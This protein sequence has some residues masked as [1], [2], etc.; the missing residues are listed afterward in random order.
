MKWY[1]SPSSQ[2]NNRYAGGIATE[3]SAMNLVA[4]ILCAELDAHGITYMRNKPGNGANGHAAESNEYGAD[5]HLAIHTNARGA[6]QMSKARGC[7]VYCYAPDQPERLGTRLAQAVYNQ[8][9]PLT[10]TGDR[11]IKSGA[12]TMSEI[13]RTHAAAALVE[14][15][16]HDDVDGAVWI[17]DNVANIAYALLRAILSIEGIPYT[18]DATKPGT[19]ENRRCY[20][21]LVE[22][23]AIA[24]EVLE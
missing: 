15:D 6:G 17:V 16:F 3:E 20:E 11:G 2:E 23:A 13:K 4:N 21:A 19:G 1:I 5:L 7:E 18:P 12:T 9:A 8:I 14:I 22:I 24:R 10:P